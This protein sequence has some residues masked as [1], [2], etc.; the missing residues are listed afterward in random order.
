MAKTLGIITSGQKYSDYFKMMTVSMSPV[1][2]KAVKRA[3]SQVAVPAFKLR[4]SAQTHVAVQDVKIDKLNKALI[5]HY[6]RGLPGRHQRGQ[7][8]TLTEWK[9]WRTDLL[10]GKASSWR[11]PARDQKMSVLPADLSDITPGTWAI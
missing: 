10:T 1:E 6:S 7:N 4:K 9:E 2:L 5:F 8:E 11:A 3:A